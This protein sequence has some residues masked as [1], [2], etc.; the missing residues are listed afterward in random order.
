MHMRAAAIVKKRAYPYCIQGDSKFPFI[1]S[2]ISVP[3]KQNVSY[4]FFLM[5]AK[6]QIK[7]MKINQVNFPAADF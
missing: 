5:Y 1:L 7:I 4:L 3:R 6:Y 2:F